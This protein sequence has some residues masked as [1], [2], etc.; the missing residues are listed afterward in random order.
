M[1][2]PATPS[3]FSRKLIESLDEHDRIKQYNLLMPPHF[4][5]HRPCSNGENCVGLT[6]MTHLPNY[7]SPRECLTDKEEMEAIQTGKLPNIIKPC[8]LCMDNTEGFFHINTRA[9]CKNLAPLT[10]LHRTYNPV[11]MPGEYHISQT[12]MSTSKQYQHTQ[13]PRLHFIPAYYTIENDENSIPY[14]KDVGYIDPAK[15]KIIEKNQLFH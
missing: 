8:E 10:S 2:I 9:E 11:G 3:Y 5:H 1:W 13:L 14:Y 4:P 15:L 7:F 6:S 12:Y